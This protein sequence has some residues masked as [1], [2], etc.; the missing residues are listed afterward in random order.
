M[1]AI[2]FLCL[3]LVVIGIVLWRTRFRSTASE[4]THALVDPGDGGLKL[5]RQTGLWL[6][7]S[8]PHNRDHAHY[9]AQACDIAYK[10]ESIG[11]DRFSDELNLA[12]RLI[13]VDNTQVYV[14]Q[15]AES[16]V[17]AFR[18]S[19]FPGS[20]DG[21]KDWLLTNSRNFLVLPE[22]RI[23][24]DFAAAGVGARFHRGFMAALE[25]VWSPLLSAVES[26]RKTKERPIWVTGHSLG[27]AIALLAAW[28]FH[29]SFLPVHQIVTFGAPMVG[30][31]AAANAYLKEFPGK[32]FRYVDHTDMVPKMPLMSLLSNHYDHV[33]QEV[34]LGDSSTKS[35]E[36]LLAD[37]AVES[38]NAN[39]AAGSPILGKKLA[40]DEN[41]SKG[42]SLALGDLS[43]DS[44][45]KTMVENSI[46]DGVQSQ[47]DAHMLTNYLARI[48]ET[49]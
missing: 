26:A 45:E 15:N 38:D 17:V 13:S 36:A 42:A 48:S 3:I 10:P 5:T 28:R 34:R 40:H 30:N 25:E 29:Q 24:T 37:I 11:Q 7:A 1:I 6:D 31:Q 20:L 32:I 49:S 21:F 35:A 9:L 14:G 8:V 33:Q 43:E 12:T 16:I 27:G 39:G 23:G 19:E 41:R 2:T 46:W 22:G 44:P 4:L 18:G 47:I